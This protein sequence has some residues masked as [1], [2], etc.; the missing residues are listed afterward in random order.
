MNKYFISYFKR[1]VHKSKAPIRL[2]DKI[3]YG[4]A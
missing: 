3:F 1:G 4:E 2:D